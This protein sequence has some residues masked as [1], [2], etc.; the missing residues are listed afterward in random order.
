MQMKFFNP[1]DP[2]FIIIYNIVILSLYDNYL[3]DD[4]RIERSKSSLQL[5]HVLINAEPILAHC[6]LYREEHPDMP[7]SPAFYN[8]LC[9]NP[10]L[11][12]YHY[13][14]ILT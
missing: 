5:R 8:S 11:M 14:P 3:M 10:C 4:G 1:E 13:P 6:T 9:G 2:I 7:S 12:I